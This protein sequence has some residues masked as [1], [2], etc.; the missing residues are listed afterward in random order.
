MPIDQAGMRL[1]MEILH[2]SAGRLAWSLAVRWPHAVAMPRIM[3][4]LGY[5]ANPVAD[6]VVVQ[7][8]ML[9]VAYL[10]GTGLRRL[11][12]QGSECRSRN[13]TC[14][15][16]SLHFDSP[17]KVAINDRVD[18][19]CDDRAIPDHRGDYVS[20]RRGPNSGGRRSNGRRTNQW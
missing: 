17:M 8:M 20:I 9:P 6:A 2:T 15:Q 13:Q 10:V 16:Q 12:C 3:C 11:R 19:H 1:R 14:K 18:S 4:S 7:V 5:L